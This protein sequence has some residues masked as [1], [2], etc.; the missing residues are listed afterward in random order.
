MAVVKVVSETATAENTFTDWISATEHVQ[1][2]DPG[3]GWLNLS[4]SGTFVATVTLQRRFADDQTARD[5]EAYTAVTDKSIVDYEPGVEYRV[6]VKTGGYGSGSV[7]MR[8][9]KQGAV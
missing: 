9:S 7:V 4:V 2:S 6:G 8:L 5:V 1:R 3:V